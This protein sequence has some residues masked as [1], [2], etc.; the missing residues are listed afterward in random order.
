MGLRWSAENILS[1]RSQFDRVK[2]WSNRLEEFGTDETDQDRLDFYLAFLLNC[3]ALR[4]WFINSNAISPA[5][6]DSMIRS[7]AAMRL[8]RDVC[9]RSKH[10]MLN[11]APSTEVNFSI[12]REYSTYGN[13]FFVIALGEKRDLFKVAV[14][15]VT[16]WENFIKTRNPPEPANPFF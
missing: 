6:V 3:Y 15:C 16:F 11:Q 14:A 5:D 10:L 9:N 13:R 2:R 8:C 7:N 4:D 12:G 1:W